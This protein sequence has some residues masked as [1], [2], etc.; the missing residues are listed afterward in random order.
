MNPQ[1]GNWTGSDDE[2]TAMRRVPAIQCDIYPRALSA[3]P[4]TNPD[5]SIPA[6][7]GQ[8]IKFDRSLRGFRV[9]EIGQ[10]AMRAFLTGHRY[11]ARLVRETLITPIAPV[12][13]T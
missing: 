10:T 11:D 8:G 7:Q 4:K 9:D 2:R 13:R 3:I 1:Y 6:A 12:G 5:M